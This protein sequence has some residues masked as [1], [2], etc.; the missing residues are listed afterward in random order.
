MALTSGAAVP[1]PSGAGGKN[2]GESQDGCVREHPR[3]HPVGGTT[4]LEFP[5]P[6]RG[7]VVP[8]DNGLPRSEVSG[9][10]RLALPGPYRVP[11]ASVVLLLVS[12]GLLAGC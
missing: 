9:R 10:D 4:G 6:G 7:R 1:K 2:Q 3:S 12:G 5:G 8:A 11:L